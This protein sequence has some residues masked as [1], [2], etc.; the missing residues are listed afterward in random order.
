M[1]ISKYSILS[2]KDKTSKK[3]WLGNIIIVR[4]K[5]KLLTIINNK[6]TSRLTLLCFGVKNCKQ[7]AIILEELDCLI[8]ISTMY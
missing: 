3:I 8:M 1:H 4:Q 7:K 5:L 6:N 2:L